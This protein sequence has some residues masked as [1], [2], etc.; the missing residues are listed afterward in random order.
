MP[1]SSLPSEYGI[2]AFSKEAYEFVDFL[3]QAGQIDSSNQ[4]AQNSRDS[5]E[6]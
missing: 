2:G 5:R 1:V 6:K 4:E 3:E